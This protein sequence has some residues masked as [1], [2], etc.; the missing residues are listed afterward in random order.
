MQLFLVFSVIFLLTGCLMFYWGAKIKSERQKDNRDY[1]KQRQETIRTI[2]QLKASQNEL[3]KLIQNDIEQFNS[4]QNDIQI[5]IGQKQA[6][7]LQCQ[8]AYQDNLIMEMT[9][10][11]TQ[12][13]KDNLT[14]QVEELKSTLNAAA[15][16]AARDEEK[17]KRLD[18]YTM[19][20]DGVSLSDVQKLINLKKDFHNPEV[21]SKLIW[22]QYFQK[23]ATDLC[24]RLI[25]KPAENIGV[26]KITNVNSGMSYIGQSVDISTRWKTHIKHGLGID[27]SSTNKFYQA[28]AA[29][30]VWNFSFEI[31]E[32]CDRASL[33][34]CQ[35]KWIEMYE[36]NIYGYNTQAGNKE[37]KV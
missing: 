27:V 32:N 6:Q 28:M 11:T 4:L 12:M 20:I 3:Q 23:Q 24:N 37:K 26:Y 13:K 36:T 31:L 35:R 2:Q 7:E 33:D 9:L 10:K 19:Y 15:R 1:Q 22:T 5:K 14:Q 34:K 30:G 25:T 29:E 16:A 18:F 21:I 8:K 17:K